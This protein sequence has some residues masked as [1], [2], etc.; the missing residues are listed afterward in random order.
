MLE[1]PSLTAED[2][3]FYQQRVPGV[4][5]FLGAGDVPPLH[6]ADFHFDE[7]ILEQGVVLYREL[8]DLL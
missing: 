3:S 7:N 1:T 4:F 6:A 8:L 5:F 2:F